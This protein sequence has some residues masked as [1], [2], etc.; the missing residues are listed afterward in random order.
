MARPLN[1]SKW[2]NIEISDDEDDTHPNI[3]T[4]SLFKWRHESRVKRMEELESK[5]KATSDE[6]RKKEKEIDALKKKMASTSLSE[7]EMAIIR[8]GLSEL[9]KEA[10]EVTEREKSVRDEEQKLPWN[11]DTISSDGFSKSIINKQMP[12]SNEHLTEEER[13]DK[14]RIFVKANEKEIKEFGWLKKYDDSKAYMTERPYLACEETANYLVIHCLNLELQE[15]CA[16]MEQVAHQCICVQYL[17]EL[18]KQLDVDPRSCISSFFTKIQVADPEYR[19][20]FE[21]ELEAFK[22]RIRK[23]AIEKLK[24]QIEETK[25]EEEIERQ[26]RLGPGGLDPVEV[27]ESLPDILKECFESQDIQ[28]LQETIKTM[29]E[30]D[31]RYH[32]KRC[33]DSGLWKPAADDPDTNPEDGFR[34]RSSE[35]EENQYE[36]LPA[37]KED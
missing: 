15:K 12:R 17:L 3:D 35:T 30:E 18:A 4:P 10:E 33:V 36:E 7:H 2:D 26:A 20:A 31:A 9:E 1:Y 27:F 13:E 24:E 14:M 11:V 6:K 16:A 28:K 37:K 34:K 32:M 23:R 19:K 29:P 22:D 25:K 8:K 21:D 5:K